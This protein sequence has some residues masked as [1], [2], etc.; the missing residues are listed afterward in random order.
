MTL[1]PSKLGCV[2]LPL[3]E[4]CACD[5]MEVAGEARR[6]KV[7]KKS[8]QASKNRELK[9][10]RLERSGN[11]SLVSRKL[12]LVV[13]RCMEMKARRQIHSLSLIFRRELASFFFLRS[14]FESSSSNRLPR[15][16]S[17]F[18]IY[19][20]G[21]LQALSEREEEKRKEGGLL[22]FSLFSY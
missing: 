21:S 18:M 9:L 13:T 5:S 4:V 7:V 20:K 2:L 16:R 8:R 3:F 17:A 10:L 15:S 19:K 12:C 11:F 14:S 6:R 22:F 1:V